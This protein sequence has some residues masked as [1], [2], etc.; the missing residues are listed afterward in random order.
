MRQAADF[1]R[2]LLLF[3]V[4]WPVRRRPPPPV[5][6]PSLA[7]IIAEAAETLA[8]A[9]FLGV[10]R[11]GSDPHLDCRVLRHRQRLFGIQRRAVPVVEEVVGRRMAD[12][13]RVH[14]S[15]KTIGEGILF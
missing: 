1:R 3:D 12:R 10:R 8:A 14:E 6:P 9:P 11:A 4:T 2:L 15:L 7:E 13:R 5:K